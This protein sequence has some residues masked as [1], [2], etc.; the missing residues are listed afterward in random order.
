MIRSILILLG[1]L[2]SASRGPVPVFFW[3]GERAFAVDHA[4]TGEA[5]STRD[6][7]SALRQMIHPSEHSTSKLGQYISS[8]VA[9]EL[10]VAFVA[11]QW[12][13]RESN[14]LNLEEVLG[15]STSSLIAPYL[16][17]D[18]RVSDTLISAMGPNSRSR[19]IA[20]HL[21]GNQK[22]QDNLSGC[23][24]LMA[25]LHENERI[26]SDGETQ[27]VLTTFNKNDAATGECIRR[28]TAHVGAR[29]TEF[30]ALVSA[31]DSR[32]VLTEFEE[33]ESTNPRAPVEA[34]AGG[35]RLLQAKATNDTTYAGPQYITPSILFGILLSFFLL[36]MLWMDLSCLMTVEGPVRFAYQHPIHSTTKEY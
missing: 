1:V 7:S 32:P 18:G 34:V 27:L 20:A 31:D 17:P 23:D 10:V 33:A 8:D 4:E 19:V 2:V 36:F 29:T 22:I 9:P 15:H 6:L 21:S 14:Q 25:A 16:Y 30:I 5:L 28:V 11:S 3:S 12:D 26:F 13:P 24:A 35:R